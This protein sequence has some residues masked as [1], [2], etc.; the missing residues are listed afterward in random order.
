MKH[1]YMYN[2]FL[3]GRLPVCAEQNHT[4][5]G[6]IDQPDMGFLERITINDS[7]SARPQKHINHQRDIQ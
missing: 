7:M 1:I 2:M 3:S 6:R 4:P 5:I